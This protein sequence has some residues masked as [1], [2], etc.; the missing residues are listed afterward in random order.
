MAGFWAV[1][2]VFFTGGIVHPPS[3]RFVLRSI[4]ALLTPQLWQAV[5]II[6]QH[7][8]HCLQHRLQ[9]KAK[10]SRHLLLGRGNRQVQLLVN[11]NWLWQKL[12]PTKLP[13]A[14][15]TWAMFNIR[16]L[17]CIKALT[18]APHQHTLLLVT[19]LPK[20]DIILRATYAV[21]NIRRP[22]CIK[23]LIKVPCAHRLLLVPWL[24]QTGHHFGSYSGLHI[25]D[26]RG[27]HALPTGMNKVKQDTEDLHESLV[28]EWMNGRPHAV[29]GLA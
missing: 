8:Q 2:V 11:S 4:W 9:V 27:R 26:H 3:H 29:M 25:P 24:P 13:A 17:C 1:L 20:Q 7:Q 15:A 28:D 12:F 19:W 23:T 5:D 6:V 21:S 18:Q 22:C 16:R 10:P 14:V